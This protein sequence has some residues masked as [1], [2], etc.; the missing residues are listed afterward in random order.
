ML[1]AQLARFKEKIQQSVE[2]DQQNCMKL[3]QRHRGVTTQDKAPYYHLQNQ[4]HNMVGIIGIFMH[5]DNFCRL[6]LLY[7]K[8]VCVR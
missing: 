2:T 6:K 8:I 4:E 5:Q 1:N 3:S 7:T